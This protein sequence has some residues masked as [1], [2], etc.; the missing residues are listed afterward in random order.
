MAA[1]RSIAL[2]KRNNYETYG[3]RLGIT[4]AIVSTIIALAS[5]TWA[6]WD[7]D[8]SHNPAYCSAGTIRTADRLSLLF[9]AICGI[10]LATLLGVAALFS[11]NDI[12]MKRTR[13]NLNSSYQLHE[14]YTVI[15]LIL[16]LSLFQT[17]CYAIF[18]GSSGIV[19]AF[20]HNITIVEYR[21]IFAAIYII[22]YY[23]LISPILMWS[24]IRYS[25]RL[26]AAKLKLLTKKRS[27][28]NEVYF[29]TYSDMWNS[30]AAIKQ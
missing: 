21:T 9:F 17:V 8:F 22:P 5:T 26:K 16:P 18:A 13:F 10:D 25:Q 12:A 29:K 19:S 15:R 11:C 7:E 20:F 23:T 30:V 24:I 1:E 27:G 14:N 6:M 4:F 28:E 3:P 2:W